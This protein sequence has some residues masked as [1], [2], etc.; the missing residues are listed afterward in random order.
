MN[1]KQL[2]L[3][4]GRPAVF[5]L[6]LLTVSVPI[7]GFAQCSEAPSGSV[8]IYLFDLKSPD[9]PPDRL[10]KFLD[11]LSFQLNNGIRADLKSRGLLG[12]AVFGVRWCS[13]LPISEVDAAVNRGKSLGSAG[14]MWGY[15]DQGSGQLRSTMRF[16]SLTEKPITDLSNII[17]SSGSLESL[18]EVYRA[19]AAYLLGKMYLRENEVSLAR[20][21]LNYARELRAL[22]D[23]LAQDLNATLISMDQSS[24]TKKLA[25]VGRLGK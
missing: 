1:W 18:G 11:R 12:N 6:L 4:L 5:L 24:S 17:F 9:I 14:V 3:V 22:P 23:L 25:V 20:R 15:I 2:L 19:F 16:T 8:T 21:T 10:H 13:G 7:T